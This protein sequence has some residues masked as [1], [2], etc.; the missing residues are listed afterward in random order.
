MVPLSRLCTCSR[1]QL[2]RFIGVY[3]WDIPWVYWLNFLV[4]I[5]ESSWGLLLS[6]SRCLVLSNKQL[7]RHLGV[8][9]AQI[10]QAGLIYFVCELGSLPLYIRLYLRLNFS[11]SHCNHEVKS[12]PLNKLVTYISKLWLEPRSKQGTDSSYL[13]VLM[14]SLSSQNSRIIDIQSHFLLC[15]QVW[16]SLLLY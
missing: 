11:S 7:L 14:K 12:P 13:S 8:S 10:P 2:L 3:C 15:F 4:S 5:F 6:L 9:C 16:M 1:C